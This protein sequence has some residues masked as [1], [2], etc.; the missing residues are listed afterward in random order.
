MQ[1][2]RWG[3]DAS[4]N[5]YVKLAR[6]QT[7]LAKVPARTNVWSPHFA[8]SSDHPVSRTLPKP[9][10]N[11]NCQITKRTQK[12][13][14]P[15]PKRLT[16][17]GARLLKQLFRVAVKSCRRGSRKIFLDLFCGDADVAKQLRA[18]GFGV[19]SVDKA[20]DS[21]LDMCDSEVVKVLEGWIRSNCI[22]GVWLA[23]PSRTWGHAPHEPA[24]SNWPRASQIEKF[25]SRLI[26]SIEKR[27]YP[28]FNR[29]FIVFNRVIFNRFFNLICFKIQS[30]FQS[31]IQSKKRAFTWV[32]LG[33]PAYMYFVSFC[34]PGPSTPCV[35][36]AFWGYMG[37]EFAFS[38]QLQHS[39]GHPS[40]LSS[41]IPENLYKEAFQ[42]GF[43]ANKA[44]QPSFFSL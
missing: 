20:L 17:T 3:S 40:R 9:A 7:E 30:N 16:L 23:T 38:S 28:K 18:R 25:Q 6:L 24:G 42:P 36:F 34:F 26:F 19:V 37:V 33:Y 14:A 35:F 5:R 43:F 41:G 44:F 29:E 12:K 15:L 31:E 2:G 27:A 13:G 10:P 8:K 22:H 21:S 11:W 32:F 39:T 1:R 4:L